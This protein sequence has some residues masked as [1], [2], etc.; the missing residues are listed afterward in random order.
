MGA[1]LLITGDQ[2][3]P[4]L[5]SLKA[6]DRQTDTLLM[7]EVAEEA[8]S[9][10]HHPKKLVFIFSA[11]RHFAEQLQ[12]NGWN[13]DYIKLEDPDNSQNFA[14]EIRR[15]LTRHNANRLLLTAASEWRVLEMM[16]QWRDELDIP[17]EILEDDR[18]LCSTAR[19][20]AWASERKQLRM[21]YFYRE[22]RRDWQIL[23]EGDKPAGGKWNFDSENRKPPRD[24]LTVPP[25]PKITPDAITADVIEL[26][27]TRFA[28]HPGEI[29][30]FSYA[31]T[32]AEAEQ[33]LAHFITHRLADFGSWQDAM[34]ADQPFMFHALIGLYLNIGLL[35]PLDCIKQAEQAWQDGRVAINAAEGFI[36]QILGWREYVRGLY[37]LSMPDYARLNHLQAERPLPGFFWNGQTEMRCLSITVTQTLE[38]AYAHHIQRLMVTGNFALL[39]G[40]SPRAVNDWYL[41]VYADAFEWVELPNVTGMALYADGGIMA[42][43]PYAASGAYINRMSDYCRGCAYNPSEKLSENSCP[44]NY[45]YWDFIARH[46]DK[47]QAN[48]RMGMMVRSWH[49]MEAGTQQALRGKAADFLAKLG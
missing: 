8:R 21:E 23:L 7:V 47:W 12:E 43:K 22:M 26:V 9:V 39:A 38:N 48:A 32:H 20:E 10:L 17:V 35:S 40:L 6:A 2:L 18:F 13:I 14:G 3:S 31:T 5:A 1:L 4:Q 45:L 37:W 34:L 11:M 19:F 28:D 44:F 27:A 42:S 46:E 15:A 25:I 30:G 36:R 41:A 29:G 16:R 24:G 49:K 33:H